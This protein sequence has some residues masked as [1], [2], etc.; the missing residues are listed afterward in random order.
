M[1][2]ELIFAAAVELADARERAAYLDQACGADST[3][4][5]QVE[6]LLAA[7]TASESFLQVPAAE[8]FTLT[9]GDFGSQ[10]SSSPAGVI[11][12]GPGTQVGSYKLLERLGEGGFGVVYR[13]E[14]KQPV[15]RQVALKII[16]PG[17]DTAE[18]IA[19]FE[20]ER[21]ALAIMDHQHIARV[22]D[23]GTTASGRPYFV[24][25]LVKGLPITEYCDRHHLSTQNRLQLFITICEAVQHAHQKGIIHRDIKPSNVLVTI[26][27]G[28]PMVKVIDFGVA[29]ATSQ[30]L[31]EKT[32]FTRQGQLVGTLQYMSPEQ[33][34]MSAIDV[35]TRSDIY[36]LGVLL[37]ELLTGTTPI[38]EQRL[39]KSAL[40][41][42]Q[43]I[44]REEDPPK[45]S[46][47]VSD[48]VA[49]PSIAAQRRIEPKKLCRLLRGEL[50]WIVLKSLEKDRTRRYETANGLAMDVRRY[51]ADEP[52]L[53]GPPSTAYRL[54]KFAHKNL[55]WLATAA[56]FVTLLAT[57]TIVTTWLA[58]AADRERRDALDARNLAM[59]LEA[60][61]KSDRNLAIDAR[62][63]AID[64]EA[65]ARQE[66]N[67]A[68]R[69]HVLAKEAHDNALRDRDQ[70]H[71][72]KAEEA[73]QREIAETSLYFS[74]IALAY[75]AWQAND[76]RH[77]LTLLEQCTPGP[78]EADRRH[79]EWYYLNALCNSELLRFD[80]HSGGALSVAYSQDG[81]FLAS[82][83][84]GNL[85]YAN[86]G[87]EIQPGEVILRDGV[88]GQ[89]LH[90]LRGHEHVIS[91]IAFSPDGRWI[92]SASYDESIRLWSTETGETVRTI[93]G[94]S[95]PIVS[96]A[97]GPDG[98]TLY[99]ASSVTQ[100]KRDDL[101][102]NCWDSN[103]GRLLWSIPHVGAPLAV[104]PGTALLAV[105]GPGH[106]LEV[107]DVNTRQQVRVLTGH[108]ANLRCAAFSPD[109]ASLV[110]G[111]YD[112]SMRAWQT[113]SGSSL[114]MLDE[115]E[116][117]VCSVAFDRSGRLLATAGDDTTIRIRDAA[118]WQQV[119]IIRGH[120][121]VVEQ[122]AFDP[123]HLRLASAGHDGSIRVWDLTHDQR[124]MAVGP[125]AH[126]THAKGDLKFRDDGDSLVVALPYRDSFAGIK[127]FATD[128]GAFLGQHLLPVTGQLM[129]PRNDFTISDDGQFLAAPRHDEAKS[130]SVWETKTGRELIT[131]RGHHAAVTA[132]AFSADNRWV[133]TAALQKAQPGAPC[134]VRI[135]EMTTGD[136]VKSVLVHAAATPEAIHRVYERQEATYREQLE[137]QPGRAD[138]CNQLAWFLVTCPDAA[139]WN[140]DEAVRLAE[141]A[142]RTDPDK[143]G[144]WNTLAVA[145]Y[146]A[147]DHQK[148]LDT[149]PRSVMQLG[150]TAFDMFFSA[151]AHERLGHSEQARKDYELAVNWMKQHRPTDQELI[152]F[153]EEA[154]SLLGIAPEGDSAQS[155]E[156]ALSPVISALTISSDR[157]QLAVGE[158]RV[159]S[160]QVW[161]VESGQLV[162]F[163]LESRET[164]NLAFS[165]DGTR[166]AAV[167]S[168][169]GSTHVWDAQSGRFMFTTP[170]P[171]SVGSVCF[172]PDGRRLAV[173]GYAGH[174]QLLDAVTGQEI[175]LLRGFGPPPG[176]RGQTPRAV[177]SSDGFRLAAFTPA[178][179]ISVWDARPRPAIPLER[180]L[181]AA[182]QREVGHGRDWKSQSAQA[183]DACR[184]GL[185]VEA[186]SK[187][188]KAVDDGEALNQ[189]QFVEHTLLQGIFNT[190]PHY[191]AACRTLLEQ[192][193]QSDDPQT[194]L[195]NLLACVAG[196]GVITDENRSQF[197]AIVEHRLPEDWKSAARQDV[198]NAAID[199]R[200][201]RNQEALDRLGS[202]DGVAADAYRA[203][204][205]LRLGN[206]DAARHCLDRLNNTSA[207]YLPGDDPSEW[208]WN[209][210]A[211]MEA[212][213][214]FGEYADSLTSEA[215]P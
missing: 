144:I 15:H 116:G 9:G 138:L 14:Q 209:L 27:E 51:L 196:P 181:A 134:E 16:K 204:I 57:A 59:R 6:A 64:L 22:L 101:N 160:V 109:G 87:H 93:R 102:V 7:H 77:T 100:V 36:S 43:R 193:G 104:H 83:G 25:E 161:D 2:E 176:S 201:G 33:A 41:E 44:I 125:V 23:G 213:R 56:A 12:E 55:K 136:V 173:V 85:F 46:T 198:L 156:H 141:Q 5:R 189:Q 34:A 76:V 71:R 8:E 142:L 177:F 194:A 29:K 88:T 96:L 4:R 147:G 120:V 117:S 123:Q 208:L 206:I 127:S 92:A 52:V 170:A 54:R 154:R 168:I 114:R 126:F 10:R 38:D 11:L 169:R 74:R 39:R 151:M 122:V 31:T 78:Q 60:T 202:T 172:S 178:N 130:V 159:G 140:A 105:A 50:D 84:G 37:F 174:V 124:G 70:A 135:W 186:T 143:F 190:A 166:L 108:K 185:F 197:T 99:S 48:S 115:H 49:L 90:T 192:H 91:D 149:I 111:G 94:H 62:N 152:Q 110:A 112:G 80:D 28:Q 32:V 82:A 66:R 47:R 69:A 81:R 165:P 97:F 183:E 210:A 153:R 163:L 129:W 21:Q 73:R 103:S 155:P 75:R 188:R 187:Y 175:L 128:A 121:D 24:M 67:A 13:A 19:R 211:R 53:A 45:P 58:V 79:W 98:N 113:S 72:A 139:F 119:A 212:N 40:T 63:R 164:E 167:D 195:G 207:S 86:P 61:A 18:V 203:I 30:R 132:V 184:R 158:V 107:W 1:S 68:I 118:T 42:V 162:H 199:L 131:L 17:M 150:V 133:V 180:R 215:T 214:L 146:R 89:S 106:Q 182:R 179:T 171:K 137:K 20:T 205:M 145:H 3:L 35:D 200:C 95:G 26:Y 157:R 148:A 65:E 191:E